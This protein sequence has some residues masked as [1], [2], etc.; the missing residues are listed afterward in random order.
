MNKIY[1]V[2]YST[3]NRNW[4]PIKTRQSIDGLYLHLDSAKRAAKSLGQS[5]YTKVVV[6][7]ISA[8]E[9]LITFSPE[10]ME[11][12]SIANFRRSQLAAIKRF[13][14]AD[15]TD[16]IFF[17]DLN[18]LSSKERNLRDFIKESKHDGIS[19][20]IVV[21]E[22]IR[23]GSGFSIYQYC[24]ETI[25]DLLRNIYD[26]TNPDFRDKLYKAL[27]LRTKRGYACAVRIPDASILNQAL[28]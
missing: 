20:A 9:N 18:K 17:I 13:K 19:I 3:N 1:Q 25:E 10:E 15:L 5:F 23:N 21:N 26:Y 22:E 14:K 12:K 4:K 24:Y 8:S 16:K 27:K 28:I 7:E 11:N 2:L 6:R